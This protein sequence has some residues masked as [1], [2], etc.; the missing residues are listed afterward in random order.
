MA[1][2][3]AL[4][5]TRPQY[6]KPWPLALGA[7]RIAHSL[8][9]L[10]IP[11]LSRASFCFLPTLGPY[12][13]CDGHTTVPSQPQEAGPGD[14]GQGQ[15][16]VTKAVDRPNITSKGQGSGDGHSLSLSGALG[17]GTA[18]VGGRGAWERPEGPTPCP[19]HGSGGKGAGPRGEPRHMRARGNPWRSA[20]GGGTVLG[21]QSPGSPMEAPAWRPVFSGLCHLGFISWQG[22]RPR[23]P[24]SFPKAATSHSR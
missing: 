10:M 12:S 18:W 24:T 13:T 11:G 8:Q 6:P 23:T 15:M 5:R 3:Q 20:C 7:Q 16:F 19:Q 1:V 4:V 14:Q 21:A 9:G 17:P 2:T 22:N